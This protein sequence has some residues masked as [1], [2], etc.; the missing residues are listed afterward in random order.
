MGILPLKK[1][2]NCDKC[3]FATKQRMCWVFAIDE[4]LRYR[5]TRFPGS[6]TLCHPG[7][8]P[9]PLC[10]LILKVKPDKFRQKGL[11]VDHISEKV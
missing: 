10:G 6:R 5:G 7:G 2:V 1:R 11:K 8:Y 3:S 4:I 9:F